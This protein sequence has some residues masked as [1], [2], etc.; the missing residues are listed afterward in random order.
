MTHPPTAVAVTPGPI[1]RCEECDADVRS[2]VHAE[3]DVS[4]RNVTCA[5]CGSTLACDAPAD[6]V[7]EAGPIP[8]VDELGDLR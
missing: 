5:R 1:V 2:L 7:P 8:T 4:Y 3:T 6:W